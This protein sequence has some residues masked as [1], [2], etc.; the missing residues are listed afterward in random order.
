MGCD[1]VTADNGQDGIAVFEQYKPDI[2]LCDLMMPDMDGF[3]VLD[4]IK[5][6]GWPAVFIFCTADIQE[7]T[8]KKAKEMGAHDLIEKPLTEEILQEVLK[9]HGT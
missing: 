7:E 4:A 3:E 5:K 8:Y 6:R 9:R 1:V 2:V